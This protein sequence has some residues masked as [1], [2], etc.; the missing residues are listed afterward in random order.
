MM[1]DLPSFCFSLVDTQWGI[2]RLS[3]G[4]R[5]RRILSSQTA[6]TIP[7]SNLKLAKRSLVVYVSFLRRSYPVR[8]PLST[9]NFPLSDNRCF[10]RTAEHCL[11]LTTPSPHKRFYLRYPSAGRACAA[12]QA[13]ATVIGVRLAVGV[14]GDSVHAMSWL[15]S[16][17][18]VGV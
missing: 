3:V 11:T 10:L 7:Q 12:W 14:V 4:T 17:R 9:H 15:D 16:R 1:P 2:I 8:T 6:P 13:T 18:D 5:K